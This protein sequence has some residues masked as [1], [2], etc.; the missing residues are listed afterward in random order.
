MIDSKDVLGH[1]IDKATM[2]W[3]D[4]GT[5]KHYI[6]RLLWAET[7]DLKKAAMVIG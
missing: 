4:M 2:K 1:I 5:N 6:K 7:K 3:N